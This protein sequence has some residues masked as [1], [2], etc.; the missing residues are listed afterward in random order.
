LRPARRSGAAASPAPTPHGNG[1]Y[2]AAIT[3]TDNA[4]GNSSINLIIRPAFAASYGP[5]IGIGA[6]GT[7][8]AWGA[9]M[10]QSAFATPF[11]PTGAMTVSR[12]AESCRLSPAIEAILQRDAASVVVRGGLAMSRGAGRIIGMIAD[13]GLICG[14]SIANQIGTWDAA[15]SRGLSATLGSGTNTAFGTAYGF[16]GSGQSLVGN[17]G[18]VASDAFTPDARTTVH[19]GR[20]ASGA[21]ADG[22]YD[23]I[24]IAPVRLSDARL[25]ELA[26][27][28]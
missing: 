28:A 19:L 2:R 24:G 5:A 9:Q 3:C 10:E 16:D 14:A 13:S 6:T 18:P 8:L 1:W 20:S 25:R 11:I 23:F 21:H 7:V 26:V 22:W 27:P 15:N 17:R 12:A 4:S